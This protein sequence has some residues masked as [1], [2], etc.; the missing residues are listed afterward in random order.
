MT[1]S[2]QAHADAVN[3]YAESARADTRLADALDELA[4]VAQ[5]IRDLADEHAATVDALSARATELGAGAPGAHPVRVGPGWVSARHVIRKARI[6]E[7]VYAVIAGDMT[8]AREAAR[9]VTNA[10]GGAV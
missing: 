10:Q 7:A 6:T 4:A 9:K 8:R 3:A 1:D 2:L 5:K